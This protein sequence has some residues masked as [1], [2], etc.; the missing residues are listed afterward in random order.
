MCSCVLTAV[1]A[2]GAQ[3]LSAQQ[4]EIQSVTLPSD[5][6]LRIRTSKTAAL[7]KG[8]EVEGTLV[9]PV[10]LRDRIVLPEGV[11]LRGKVAEYEDV[12]KT[13]RV[14][15]LLNGDVTPLRKP[16]IIFDTIHAPGGDISI[17]SRAV[18][19]DTQVVRFTPGA[20]HQ[21]VMQRAKEM[22]RDRVQSARDAVFS[23]GKGI[24]LFGCYIAS[25]RII[26]SESG[27]VRNL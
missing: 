3:G 7:K 18:I 9:E 2:A 27:L 13:T 1:V 8:T 11:P 15:S 23:P 12:D 26:L 17:R 25:C 19:R 20:T 14:Q 4:P 6:P 21:G 24:G 16:V 22:V 10:Y 5:V